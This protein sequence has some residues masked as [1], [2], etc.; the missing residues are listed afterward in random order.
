M[1]RG[2][3]RG[4]KGGRRQANDEPYTAG[5]SLLGSQPPL[6]PLIWHPTYQLANCI[7]DATSVTAD[8]NWALTL[9]LDDTTSAFGLAGIPTDGSVVGL[10]ILMI[11]RN[12]VVSTGE[13][14]LATDYH[15][16]Q[17]TLGSAPNANAGQELY[18][19]KVA[20]HYNSVWVP[21][22]YTGGINNLQ[23]KWAAGW[24]TGTGTVYI[25]ATHYWTRADPQ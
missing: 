4:F 19:G 15:Q 7:A 20:G 21:I 12:S 22:V 23:F 25:R 16:R 18:Y 2:L 3:L 17:I 6:G 10:S 13:R 1:N 11:A 8:K 14:L 24:T 9:G 5:E